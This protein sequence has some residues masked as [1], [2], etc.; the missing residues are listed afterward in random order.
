MRV[1]ELYQNEKVSPPFS[2]LSLAD[3]EQLDPSALSNSKVAEV[4][5]GEVEKLYA[6]R[7]G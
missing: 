6:A 5:L 3:Q 7:F 1:S 4:M 2:G